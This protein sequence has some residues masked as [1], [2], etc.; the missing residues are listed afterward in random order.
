MLK[1]FKMKLT[2]P[3]PTAG[4]T[5]KNKILKYYNKDFHLMGP[6]SPKIYLQVTFKLPSFSLSLSLSLSLSP[7]Y[8]GSPSRPNGR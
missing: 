5:M 4:K 2:Y 6:C 1:T 7:K 3:Q 8:S